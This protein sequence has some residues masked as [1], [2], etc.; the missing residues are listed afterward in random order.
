M[1]FWEADSRHAGELS[2][3]VCG[4]GVSPLENRGQTHQT[5]IKSSNLFVQSEVSF[6]TRFLGTGDPRNLFGT[7]TWKLS[8]R[9]LGRLWEALGRL[10]EALGGFGRLWETLG[11]S[12]GRLWEA[13]GSFGRR[14][15]SLWEVFGRLW[16]ALGRLSKPFFSSR[17]L[18]LPYI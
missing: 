14:W 12:L 10:G 4:K 1:A 16:E 2:V 8:G 11:E 5:T 18:F 17:L 3:F 6:C 7:S 15:G 13:L 9:L